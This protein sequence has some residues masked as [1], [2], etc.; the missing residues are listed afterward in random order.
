MLCLLNAFLKRYRNSAMQNTIVE[1]GTVFLALQ[2][3]KNA[4]LNRGI[5][6]SKTA[7]M[8]SAFHDGASRTALQNAIPQL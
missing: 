6:G 3:V 8:K 1:N 2:Y 4:S 7:L 5:T